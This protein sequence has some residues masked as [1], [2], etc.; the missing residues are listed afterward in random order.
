MPGDSPRNGKDVTVLG[1]LH[2]RK[3]EGFGF[4]SLNRPTAEENMRRRIRVAPRH[5]ANR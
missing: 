2:L 1:A 5:V 4:S 3:K